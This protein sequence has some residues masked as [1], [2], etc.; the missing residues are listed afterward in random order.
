MDKKYF[1]MTIGLTILGT[2]I[3]FFYSDHFRAFTAEQARK[4]NVLQESPI[5]PNVTF[6]D[7]KGESFT[8]SEYQGKYV[9]ATF[10]YPTCGDVCPVVE[11]NFNKIY[12]SLPKRILRDKLHFISISFDPKRD[13]PEMLEH[14]REL[15][16]ADGVNWRIATVPD[17]KELKL[18]LKM[19][20]VI[21][22]PIEN[23]FEHNAAFY[24]I[25]PKGR[26]IQIYDYNSPDKVVE[27]LNLRV[28]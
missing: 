12:S 3:L 24:L 9:L 28:K 7:S 2:A 27:E 18:L 8:L 22:I 21:V 20:G 15:Y 17:Q 4:I 10:F 23:G 13:T 5:V 11:M 6:E 19:A 25:D 14:H 1:F 26:L 16:E